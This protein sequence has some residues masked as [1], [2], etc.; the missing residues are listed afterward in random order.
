MYPLYLAWVLIDKLYRHDSP[1][2]FVPFVDKF[3]Y[4]LIQE[5]RNHGV[6]PVV[7]MYSVYGTP[8]RSAGEGGSCTAQWAVV[9]DAGVIHEQ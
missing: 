2:N 6:D 8:V 4:K 3:Q 7:Q 5:I 1:L 9:E